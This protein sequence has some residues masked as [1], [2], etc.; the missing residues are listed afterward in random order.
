MSKIHTVLFTLRDKFTNCAELSF[1]KSGLKSSFNNDIVTFIILVLFEGVVR[2]GT[3]DAED[4]AELI[5]LK[6]AEATVWKTA[7][8]VK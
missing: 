8:E 4:D 3:C 1:N 5:T 2:V 7:R 6:V